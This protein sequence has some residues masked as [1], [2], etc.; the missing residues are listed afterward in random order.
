LPIS[1]PGGQPDVAPIADRLQT[2]DV[3]AGEASARK[4][5]AC[6]TFEKGGA[7]KVG[8]NLYGVV[9]NH[10]AHVEGFKFS[11]AMEEKNA[12]G[13]QWDFENLDHFLDNPRGFVPGTAMSFAGLKRPDERANVI[14][15]MRTMADAP[16]PLPEPSAPEEVSPEAQPATE[17]AP[18]AGDTAPAEGAA[19]AEDT[20]PAEGTAPESTRQD[21]A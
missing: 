14:A 7:A 9:G 17:G 15:Y 3:A 16:V 11:Q 4:C 21:T 2:A 20:A 1:A 19:P 13:M 18:P 10:A 5:A 6:H 8:P 12:E